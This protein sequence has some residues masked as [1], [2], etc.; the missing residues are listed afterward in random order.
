MKHHSMFFS[1]GKV[2]QKHE[3]Q[4]LVLNNPVLSLFSG[5]SHCIKPPAA[6]HWE[7]PWTNSF[8]GFFYGSFL[9]CKCRVPVMVLILLSLIC[10]FWWNVSTITLA[11]YSCCLKNYIFCVH[12][13]LPWIRASSFTMAMLCSSQT[14]WPN[15]FEPRSKYDPC[16]LYLLITSS[17]PQITVSP[18]QSFQTA[19]LFL[20]LHIGHMVFPFFFRNRSWRAMPI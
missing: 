1:L 6:T 16:S 4:W 14:L 7:G 2:L 19:Q 11:F 20:L 17:R 9:Q 18:Q 3:V 8:C 5:C 12:F 15:L 10:S 13:L